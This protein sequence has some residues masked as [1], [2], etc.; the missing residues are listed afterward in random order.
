MVPAEASQ[1]V[2]KL[3]ERG[4]SIIVAD[5]PVTSQIL[6]SP[7]RVFLFF[8]SPDYY[9]CRRHRSERLPVADTYMSRVVATHDRDVAESRLGRIAGVCNSEDPEQVQKCVQN[10]LGS[11]VRVPDIKSHWQD[12]GMRDKHGSL[13]IADYQLYD[14]L[15][16]RTRTGA[17]PVRASEQ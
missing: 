17:Q 7:Y 14:Y 16:S 9:A 2:L 13:D 10:V 8:N 4:V 6:E 12:L 3:I 15:K 5:A 11:P 1:A